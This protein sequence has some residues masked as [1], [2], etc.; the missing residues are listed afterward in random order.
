MTGKNSNCFYMFYVEKRKEQKVSEFR[1]Q[2]GFLVPLCPLMKKYK[3]DWPNVPPDYL[4]HPLLAISHSLLPA[5]ISNR[6]AETSVPS[7]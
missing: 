2:D 3:V 7:A 4:D 1:G 5:E 6:Q